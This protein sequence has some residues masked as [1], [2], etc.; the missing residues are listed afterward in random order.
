MKE[1]NKNVINDIYEKFNY[2][3]KNKI[4]YKFKMNDSEMYEIINSCIKIYYSVLGEIKLSPLE[5]E[6][7]MNNKE[8]VINLIEKTDINKKSDFGYTPLEV[9]I[10][11]RN[12]DISKLLIENGADVNLH[13][14]YTPLNLASKTRNYKIIELL[15]ENGANVNYLDENGFN[16]LHYLLSAR[17]ISY[18]SY[19]NLIFS[20]IGYKN[21]GINENKSMADIVELL[22]KNG[23]DINCKGKWKIDNVE[24]EINA[25][26]LA[27]EEAESKVIKKLIDYGATRE[28]VELDPDSIYEYQISFNFIEDILDG[29]ISMWIDAP[30]EYINYL[31]YIKN[32][33]KYNI[34]VNVVTKNDG[35]KR[36]KKIINNSNTKQQEN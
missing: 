6:I 25:L 32:I 11:M 13:S 21:I 22:Y 2:F 15:L 34:R 10:S 19:P 17:Y 3:E 4:P 27:V 35:Y 12:Y 18:I 31:N 36:L 16:A 28:V 8:K 29:D 5:I 30:K 7:I 1:Q 20:K 26:S 14:K 24:T 33:I 9:A 23:I